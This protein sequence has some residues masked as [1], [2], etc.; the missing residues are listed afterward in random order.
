MLETK[1]L[2]FYVKTYLRVCAAYFAAMPLGPLASLRRDSTQ[3]ISKRTLVS[4]CCFFISASIQKWNAAKFR[5]SSLCD[6][7]TGIKRFSQFGL[8][9]WL[10]VAEVTAN[11]SGVWVRT[12]GS[13]NSR[14]PDFWTLASISLLATSTAI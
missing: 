4:P 8:W 6:K 9:P 1:K 11:S 2:L 14:V 5:A 3:P 10:W 7:S 13:I 12:N